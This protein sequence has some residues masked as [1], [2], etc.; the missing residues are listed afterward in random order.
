LIGWPGFPAGLP[1]AFNAFFLGRLFG[2]RNPQLFSFVARA[3]AEPNLA[4]RVR[5]YERAS[6]L[7]MEFLPFVPYV[8]FRFAVA[9]RRNV[10]GY[11]PDT[12]GPVND[13][14]ATVGFARR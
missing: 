3:D 14:F 5:L 10:T 6:R 2:F 12:F 13:S 4:R 8:H 9:L 1:I 7:L 11:V